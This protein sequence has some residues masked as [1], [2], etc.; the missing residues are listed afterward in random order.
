M[1]DITNKTSK[2]KTYLGI[3][4]MFGVDVWVIGN[5][6]AEIRELPSHRE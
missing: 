2:T 5:E 4:V 3:M 1:K 6:K